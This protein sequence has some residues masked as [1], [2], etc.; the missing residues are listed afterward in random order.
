[1]GDHPRMRGEH[2]FFLCVRF[3]GALVIFIRSL[4]RSCCLRTGLIACS[5]LVLFCK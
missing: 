1:M 2:P 3:R 5:R 4:I